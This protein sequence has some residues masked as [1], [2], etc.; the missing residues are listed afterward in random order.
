MK[1]ILAFAALALF[2][3]CSCTQLEQEMPVVGET[4]PTGK[5]K[6]SFKVAVPGGG[7]STK[8]M[9]NRPEINNI[10]VAVFGGSGFYNE[11]VQ[12]TIDDVSE[13][14]YNGSNVYDVSVA[15]T[16]SDSRLR[17]HF[18]ANCPEKFR[19]TPPITGI[20]AQDLED[21]VMGKVRS[22]ITDDYNDA[23]WQKVLL[24]HGVKAKMVD[25]VDE[26]TG[27]ISEEYYMDGSGNYVASDATLEQF[28]DPIPLV[29]NFARIY[30][31]N[32]STDVTIAKY[33][34]VFAP[35]EGAVAPILEEAFAS[36]VDGNYIPDVDAYNGKIYYENFFR[37]YQSYPLNSSDDSVTLL[38]DAPFN[39][40]GYSPDDITY[41][42]YP[43]PNDENK[44][45]NY[46]TELEMMVWDP[47]IDDDTGLQAPMFV[48]ERGTPTTEHR[49][50][51]VLI[52]AHKEGEKD[53]NNNDLYKYY[54]LDIVDSDN[55]YIPLLR[56]QT[57]TV[58]LIGIEAG[59]GES[60]IGAA[61]GSSSAT[62]SG[63]PATQYIT[64]ISDGSASISTSYTE[65]LYVRPGTYDAFFRYIPT[66]V[67]ETAGQENNN[68]VTLEVGTKNESTGTFTPVPAAS[69]TASVFRI[70]GGDYEVSIEKSNG[71]VVLY[72]RHGSGFTNDADI[73]AASTEK[74]GRIV[75]TT[76][77]EAESLID[78]DGYFTPTRNAAIRV[79]GTYEGHTIFR[80]IL[81]KIS[82]RKQMRVVCR[83]KYV[84]QLSG[85][86]EV[87]RVYIPTDLPRA[88]FPI[89]F[90]MEGV[91][92]SLTPYGDILPVET[93]SSIIP[94]TSGPSYFFIKNLTREDYIGLSKET[95]DGVEW[96]YFDCTFKTTMPDSETT[97]YVDNIYFDDASNHDNF[98]NFTQRLFTTPQF[99]KTPREDNPL[100]VTFSMD[101]A[102]NGTTVWWDPDNNLSASLSTSNKVIPKAFLVVMEGIEPEINEDNGQFYSPFSSGSAYDPDLNDDTH[103]Y[104]YVVGSS[105]TQAS[106]ALADV[107]MR[108]VPSTGSGGSTCS[109]DISTLN[110]TEN[111]YLYKPTSISS[112]VGRPGTEYTKQFAT[113]SSTITGNNQQTL[114][115]SP[116]TVRF[117]S[118]RDRNAGYIRTNRSSNIQI[119]V[120]GSNRTIVS[121]IINFT[122][123]SYVPQNEFTVNSGSGSRNGTV[124][125]WTGDASSLTITQGYERDFRIASVY[126]TYLDSN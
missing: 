95:V 22:Q 78:G 61:A 2:V 116:V 18:I 94:N 5:V 58:K 76:I 7:P 70:S 79:T 121:V 42:S 73:V 29:R 44:D 23:Y 59:S 96:N 98:Y 100:T 69:A 16:M 75:Y 3:I 46:P 27:N 112:T 57:Y 10:Y 32:L 107:T 13:D 81:V 126:V 1:K 68:L 106:S 17:L 9:G 15:L 90:K 86:V 77:G 19:T 37:N 41:G 124:W 34:L 4:Q 47:N 26:E 119:S 6:L 74:W 89:Q 120:S 67:G 52:Y 122:S 108:V 40:A 114:T 56:N 14:N 51:R 72:A 103:Y 60:S 28:P 102:H 88:V 62:V 24:P 50:T 36:D 115:S 97:V 25:V 31:R 54:A 11:W 99:S 53:A 55:N 118:V 35:A 110:I 84:Q 30:L 21:V 49:A 8:A 123:T 83:Q 45:P 82:P 66:Y 111:P 48:Y 113:N 92:K 39:Y 85:Q 117:S 43:D 104:V 64:E 38:T 33:A 20:S 105:N 91:K 93:G 101:T 125:T 12:A 65:M 109:I 63:D 71:Q 87:V 80:D